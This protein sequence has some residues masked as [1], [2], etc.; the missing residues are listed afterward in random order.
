MARETS[1]EVQILGRRWKIGKFTA[2][3][4]SYVCLKIF[5]RI[6]HIAIGVASGELK[7]PAQITAIL[8]N[9]LG[10]IPKQE[11]MDIQKECLAVCS[12]FQNIGGVD[13]PIPVMTQDGRFGVA[14]LED[15]MLTVIALVAHVLVFN[16][17]PFFDEKILKGVIESFPDLPQP[18]Q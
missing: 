5:S 16:L 17:S 13:A 11:F 4:G 7:D 18:K 10:D 14:N 8:T 1:K 15:D 3:V 6:S 12:E 9:Q 2:L